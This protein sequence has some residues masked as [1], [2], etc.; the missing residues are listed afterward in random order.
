[1]IDAQ[2]SALMFESEAWVEVAVFGPPDAAPDWLC[3]RTAEILKMIDIFIARLRSVA[4][5]VA[6]ASDAVE[7]QSLA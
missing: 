4:T 3:G 7:T 1:V 5:A 6:L 2:L